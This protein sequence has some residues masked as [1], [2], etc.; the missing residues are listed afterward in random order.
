MS[1]SSVL[2]SGGTLYLQSNSPATNVEIRAESS[3]I[4]IAEIGTNRSWT[5]SASQVSAVEFQGGAGNDRFVNYVNSLYA[6]A[7]GF[8][9]ADYLVGANGNDYFDGGDGNDELVGGGGNDTLIGGG[10][11]DVLLGL[12]GND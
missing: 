7:F 4:R 1:I 2:F 5:Y 8:G 11:N 12:A 10:G 9:G 6:R 3:N